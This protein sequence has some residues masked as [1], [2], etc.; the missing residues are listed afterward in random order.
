MNTRIET[1]S[2]HVEAFRDLLP[3]LAGTLDVGEMFQHLTRVAARLIPHDEANLALLTDD[4]SH[5]R[6]YVTGNDH[7]RIVARGSRCLLRNLDEPELAND[8]PGHGPIRAGVSA[9]VRVNDHTYGVLALLAHRPGLYSTKDVVLVRWLADHLTI[10]LAHQRLAETAR[11]AAVERERAVIIDSSTQLLRAISSVLDIR[12]VF[13]QISHIASTLLGHDFLSMSFE[14]RDGAVVFE[15]TSGDDLRELRRIRKPSGFHVRDGFLIVDDFAVTATPIVEP[16]ALQ[17]FALSA[18]LRSLLAVRADAGAKEI[19]LWFWSKTPKG[20]AT[21]DLPI[22]R[23]IADHVALAVSHEQLAT[24][25]RSVAETQARAGKVAARVRSL[26]LDIPHHAKAPRVVG[27]SPEW[28]DVLQQAMQVAPTEATVLL[29]GESGTGKEVLARLIH[30]ESPRASGPF[31]ALNCAALPEQLLESELFG[32][33]RGAFTGAQHPK[34]GQI[35]LASG[36]VLFLDEVAELSLPA[37]AKFLRVLQEREFQRLG[38]IRRLTANLRVL[39]ATNRNLRQAVSRGDFRED[40]YY[41]LQVF[42]IKLVPLRDRPADILPLSEAFLDD[43]SQRFGHPC[44]GL[45]IDARDALLHYQWPGNVRELHN[46]LER[47]AIVCLGGLITAQHLTFASAP[48]AGSDSTTDLRCLER[49]TIARVLR[50]ANWNKARAARRL[51]LTRSQ[52]YFRLRR[53]GLERAAGDE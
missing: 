29:T 51:G 25:A 35:E 11:H 22:A 41:R 38:G 1:A 4:G 28:L 34:P 10:G 40:L 48:R 6:E 36:G 8:I 18:G 16:Q 7:D 46:T 53:H 27:H 26:T 3:A 37:Q 44:E 39:A 5:F 19:A 13:P 31:V 17:G 2:H 43:L 24:A 20:F 45:S 12:T 32:Y 15:A 47:A 50:E 14:D 49:T 30:R 33:E 42:E 21:R 9:P 52:L 23:R